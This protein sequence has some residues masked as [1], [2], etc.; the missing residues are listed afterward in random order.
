MAEIE[1]EEPSRAIPLLNE[2]LLD[3]GRAIGARGLDPPAAQPDR[4]FHARE[5][6]PA[7]R[8]C[9][10][11]R[12]LA[13][14]LDDT[15]LRAAA[16]AGLALIRFNAGKPGC[17]PAR[18]AGTRARADR[19]RQS[20]PPTPASHSRTFWSGRPTSTGHAALLESL[21]RE[22][23]ES[24]ER[25]RR[26]CALVSRAR[27]A[28]SG[29]AL[30]GRRRTPSEARELTGAVR[31]RRGRIADE[32]PPAGAR[33]RPPRATSSSPASSQSRSAGSPSCTRRRSARL[34]RCSG[35]SIS[36]A[37]TP[38]AAVAGFATAERIAA[39]GAGDGFDPSMCWWRAEQVEALLELGLVD[40]AVSRLDSVGG[41]RTR[42]RREWVA[43]ARDTLPRTRR[44]C[45]RR[46]RRGRVLARRSSHTAR[47]SR[48]PVRPR[49]AR[50]SRSASFAGGRG[51]SG[52]RAR[53]SRRRAPGFEEMGAVR[54]AERAQRGARADRR[55]YAHRRSD[56]G[57][58]TRRRP[59]GEGPDERRGRRGAL[60][61]RAHGREPPDARLRQAG[62][63]LAHRALPQAS[64]RLASR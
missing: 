51:R 19:R 4:P 14:Q 56:A 54:W 43:R 57:G 44:R 40:D 12:E 53:R 8:A 64:L 26:L 58:A 25:M 7:E 18:R 52:R 2:A 34:P 28:S 29:P 24:D 50:C 39:D 27:R 13:E 31:A 33:R 46:R 49:R 61:R 32:P 48:R 5:S 30:A 17:P 45:A 38:E 55:T 62:R 60:P 59:G 15:A 3:A 11:R 36:G 37:G 20:P 47:G 22:W 1:L 42:L 63:A 10:R 41:G 6:P 35:S 21:Y 9:A 23:S 16:M